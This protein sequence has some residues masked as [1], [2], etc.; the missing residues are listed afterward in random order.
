MEKKIMDIIWHWIK[1][2]VVCALFAIVLRAFIF[3]PVEV[4]GK[5]MSPTI[6]ENDFVVM[7][8]FSEI[9]R[10]D[11]IV[12]TSSDG[13]TYVKRV[14]GL[15]GDHVKYEKDQL[16]INGKKL[17]EPF[18]DGVKKHKNE[19]VFTTDLD[20]ADLI[21]TKKIPKDQYFVLGDNRRLSKDSRSFGTINSSAILGQARIVYY[22]LFHSKIVK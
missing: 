3:V 22:P 13:N 21:G 17:E 9:K 7:E 14:I 12:F 5:S 1:M 2:I 8:N 18:L 16:Y 20:S 15:P 11:V 19:Y 6:K 4:T 10:F